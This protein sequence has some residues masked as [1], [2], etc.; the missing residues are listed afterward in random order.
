MKHLSALNKYFWK[1]RWRLTLGILFIVLSN[2]FRILARIS[3]GKYLDELL[4]PVAQTKNPQLTRQALIDGDSLKAIE[5]Y[6]QQAGKIGVL[7]N[8]DDIILT[9]DE[10]SYLKQLF[11]TRAKIYPRGAHC[12][13]IN[14]KDV[15][16]YVTN[17][18][19]SGAQP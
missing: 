1:Y 6:L 14:H 19:N 10:L 3:F 4:L 16:A 5:G 9:A 17:Y 8:E 2:Y 7:T 12:G 13:N 11:G 15:A 18:F